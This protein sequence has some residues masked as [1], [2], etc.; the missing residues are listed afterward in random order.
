MRKMLWAVGVAA[1]TWGFLGPHAQA[2]FTHPFRF[3]K[4][5]RAE[6]P[7]TPPSVQPSAALGARLY[8][9]AC[10]SCHGPRGNGE[11]FWPLPDGE[12]APALDSLGPSSQAAL[13]QIIGQ[14]KGMMPGWSQVMNPT[15]IRSLVLYVQSL[16]PPKKG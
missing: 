5:P 3:F 14:G 7:R 16:N 6:A 11:G 2:A 15:E 9:R 1:V 10:E 13:H 4:R 12:S 8:V